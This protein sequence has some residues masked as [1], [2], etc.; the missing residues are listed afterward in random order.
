MDALAHLTT[1]TGAFLRD[2]SQSTPELPLAD[3]RWTVA[4]LGAHLGEVHRWAAGN[5]R[6]GK[7]GDRQNVPEIDVPLAEWYETSRGVLLAALDELD[8][9]AECYT[10]SRSDRTV[11]FWHR[12][13]L[14]ET[15][16]HLWDLRSAA[17]PAAPP[18]EEVPAEVHADG[19]SELFDV[20][21]SRSSDADRGDL[22]GGIRLV[23]SDTGDQW[24]FDSQW[25]REGGHDFAATVTA[26]AGDLLLWVW[27]R[28]RARTVVE[29]EGDADVIRRFERAH[30]RP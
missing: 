12:R 23:A 25:G 15:L 6:T 24:T 21:L 20:F 22:G 8:P 5:A 29:F 3:I 9:E 26:P 1:V 7:R 17:D 27:N 2:L 18:P 28:G 16:V 14:H 4:E 11:R 19:V 10:L 30:V 13:Q